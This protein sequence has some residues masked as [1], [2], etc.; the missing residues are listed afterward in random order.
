[1][2]SDKAAGYAVTWV[3]AGGVERELG[4]QQGE[5]VVGRSSDCDLVLDD[6]KTS[7]KHA[8]LSVDGS[9]VFV[10]DL[11]SRNGTFVNGERVESSDLRP[12]DEIRIGDVRLRLRGAAVDEA[13]AVDGIQETIISSEGTVVLETAIRNP[14]A[15]RVLTP[16]APSAP[17]PATSDQGFVP[18]EL[19]QSP[20]ISEAALAE[21]GVPVKVVEYVALGGGIGSFVWVDALRNSGVPAS[22]IAVAS[23]EENPYARYRRL[24]Q[25]S[26]IP[27]HERLRSNSDSCPDNIWGFPGY[28]VREIWREVGLGNWRLA[29]KV[30]WAIFGEPTLA[31]SYSPKT[32]DVWQSMD[33]EIPRI[34]WSEMLTLGRIRAIRKTEEGRILAVVSQSTG[35]RR[36]HVAVAGRF[37]HLAPGYPA[38]QFLPDLA[39]FREK[40]DDRTKVVS[41]YEDHN[42]V[43]EHLRQ[44]GGTVLLRGRGIVASRI[45]QRLSEERRN[46]E[47]IFLVHLHRS[48]LQGGHQ[49]GPSSRP[50]EDDFELQP[51][52]W[53]KSCWGG[54]AREEL[55]RASFEERKRLMDVWGGTTTADRP[56]WQQIIK[57]G[58]REG[59]YRP[60][61]GVVE[62]LELGSEGKVTT[63]ISS[64]LAGGGR[65]ELEADFVIDCTGLIAASE[66]SPML[67]DLIGTYHIAKNP[68]GR[69]H[70]SNDFEL[71]ELRHEGSHM[72]VAGACILGGPYAP[73]DSFL[74]LQYAALRAIRHMQRF[75]PKELRELNGLYSFQ[76]WTKWAR[77]ITP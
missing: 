32:E 69:L 13:A 47:N 28:A 19:L 65:L 21:N 24:V 43:Y 57:D 3:D 74:G 58:L 75:N 8:R 60:E 29:A 23:N 45:I 18:D 36:R 15:A 54:Q 33:R 55:E 52:N 20:I 41:A 6:A 62:N 67:A 22:D 73:V 1:M 5:L 9:S 66:R 77:G 38:L 56:D 76:Q 2:S 16:V 35:T 61:Y 70:C 37:L 31:P 7:R 26:Q 25:N 27:D 51:F 48:K 63:V 40:Y 4:L 44:H 72:Y 12:D 68:L 10:E 17:A 14:E 11:G 39:E 71:E 34:G 64:R 30:A 49:F 50:T 42:H 46:N 59:W 53:P